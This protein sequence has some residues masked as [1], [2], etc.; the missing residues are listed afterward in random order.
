MFNL[1]K[2]DFA[3]HNKLY[4]ITAAILFGGFIAYYSLILYLHIGTDVQVHAGIAFAFFRE[5]G[6][7]TPNFLYYFL[8]GL[9]AAFSKYKVAYYISSVILL[10]A[11]IAFKFLVNVYYLRKYVEPGTLI[12]TLLAIILLFVYCLPGVNFFEAKQFYLGQLAPNVWHNSTVIFL[13]PFSIILFFETIGFLN[14]RANSTS[15]QFFIFILIL[16]NAVIKPS[17]LFTI[18]PT[19]FAWLGYRVFNLNLKQFLQFTL[20][21]AAGMLLIALEYFLI[22]KLNTH[23][24]VISAK[25]NSSVIISPFEMWNHFSANIPVAFITSCLFPIA[26]A[27]YSKGAVFK[28]YLVSFASINFLFAILIWILFIETG[29]RRYHGNFYWQLVIANYLLFFTMLIRFL[30]QVK[31]NTIN[32]V[33]KKILFVIFILHFLW[34]V[35]YWAKIIWYHGYS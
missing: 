10:S 32:V 28:N 30:Q 24:T 8:T 27:V 18:I 13:T 4:F 29:F 14:Q 20:P 6:N 19:V 31:S 34:G 21:Y 15:K 16:L 26:Y 33:A 5:G 3:N 11:A 2:P 17:F 1:D 7:I 9:L 25:E 35:I 12:T 22:Y 23:S